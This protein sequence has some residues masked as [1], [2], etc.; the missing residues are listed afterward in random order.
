MTL[1][2][3]RDS[4]SLAWAYPAGAKGRVLVSGA[5]EGQQQRPFQELPAGATSYVV[6]G[7]DQDIDFC[8]TVAVVYSAQSVGRAKPVCTAREG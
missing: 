1:R 3:N 2:D 8:F 4:I 6:H 7:L 5:P